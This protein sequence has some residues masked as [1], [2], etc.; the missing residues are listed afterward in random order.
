MCYSY[1]NNFSNAWC[2]CV[3][4]IATILVMLGVCV[5]LAV[6]AHVHACIACL[7]ACDFV[8]TCMCASVSK[9]IIVLWTCMCRCILNFLCNY[10]FFRNTRGV[11]IFRQGCWWFCIHRWP[12]SYDTI[13]WFQSKWL[14][15]KNVNRSFQKWW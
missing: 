4:V 14:R 3:T 6:C 15:N 5:C 9:L 2:M 8:C 13:H 12:G 1:S 10:C 7:W 11:L